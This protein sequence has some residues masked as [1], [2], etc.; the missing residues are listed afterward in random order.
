MEARKE[1]TGSE[2]DR[3]KGVVLLREY[4]NYVR[5]S[6]E[7]RVSSFVARGNFTHSIS[8][9]HTH[10]VVQAGMWFCVRY[11]QGDHAVK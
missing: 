5:T 3:R 10:L 11:H 2:E 8:A 4:V 6:R 7:H 1:P 9:D